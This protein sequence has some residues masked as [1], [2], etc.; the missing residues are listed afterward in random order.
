MAL[1]GNSLRQQLR[2]AVLALDAFAGRRDHGSNLAHGRDACRQ[3]LCALGTGGRRIREG[4]AASKY[5]LIVL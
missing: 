5:R 4:C 1:S 2:I 3:R